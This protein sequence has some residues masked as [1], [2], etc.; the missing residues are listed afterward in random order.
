[1]KT[2]RF[3]VSRP[4]LTVS[5]KRELAKMMLFTQFSLCESNFRV[6]NSE[7]EVETTLTL[8][9]F[10]HFSSFSVGIRPIDRC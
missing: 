6:I 5:T 4:Y 2:K 1:M 3:F 10:A 8:N 7:K 9:D